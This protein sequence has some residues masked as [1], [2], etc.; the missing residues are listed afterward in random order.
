MHCSTPGVDRKHSIFNIKSLNKMKILEKAPVSAGK[1]TKAGGLLSALALGTAIM[2]GASCQ[3][4]AASP[5]KLSLGEDRTAV[6]VG[7][8]NTASFTYTNTF[9]SIRRSC[10]EDTLYVTDFLQGTAGGTGTPP[11]TAYNLFYYSFSTND[12]T[13]AAGHDIKFTGTANADM[14]VDTGATL[15]YAA[16]AFHSVTTGTS[17]TSIPSGVVG[18]NRTSTSDFTINTTTPGWYNYDF[19]NH[20][21]LPL[22]ENGQPIVF[23]IT[24]SSPSR[25]Y[26]LALED[27][28]SGGTPNTTYLPS[29]YPYVKF[30]YYRQ[31]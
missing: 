10:D 26:I 25:V 2:F 18:F 31:S 6:T 29:N 24:Y 15:S 5:E 7:A 21:A 27:I 8:C 28:Y 4:E 19:S 9:G 17:W 12:G 1:T 3:K 11:H 23:K 14:Y 20:K 13:N 30:R 22:I 16:V